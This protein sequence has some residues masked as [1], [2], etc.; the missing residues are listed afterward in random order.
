MEH[1]DIIDLIKLTVRLEKTR[2]LSFEEAERMRSAHSFDWFGWDGDARKLQEHHEKYRQRAFDGI[3]YGGLSAKQIDQSMAWNVEILGR[4]LNDWFANGHS[5]PPHTPTRICI[6][7]R[8]ARRLD[9]EYEFLR[10]Y[11]PHYR[12]PHINA[13]NSSLIARAEKINARWA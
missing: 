8:K 6:L 1:D 3:D 7:L 2:P 13:H 9:L 12:T 11:I 5:V 10:A 4:L